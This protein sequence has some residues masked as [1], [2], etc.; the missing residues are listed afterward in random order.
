MRLAFFT[1]IVPDGL[2]SSGFEIANE[3]IVSCLRDMG[4]EVVIFGFALPRQ[5]E[6]FAD[7]VICLGRRELENAS[8]G[9]GQKLLW[10]LRA[11]RHGLPYAAAKLVDFSWGS[12]RQAIENNG[13]FDG[14]VL[15]SYQMA[16]AFPDLTQHPHIYVA[17]NVEHLSAKQNALAAT[18]GLQRFLY[19]RDA[20]ILEKL[21][22]R[23]CAAANFVWTFSDADTV[24]HKLSSDRGATLPLFVPDAATCAA[25]D[26]RESK[27]FDAG[28]I[29]TWSWQPNLVGLQWFLGEVVPLLPKS[30][31]I[32]VAGDMPHHARQ[33]LANVTFLGRVPSAAAFLQSVHVVPLISRGGTGVQLK[34]IEAFQSGL[35]CVATSSSLRGINALPE[36]CLEADDAAS[37]AAALQQLIQQARDGDLPRADGAMFRDRQHAKMQAEIHRGLAAL[38]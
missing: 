8:A 38:A 7:N 25:S 6:N 23:L 16:A 5:S 3:A 21:E 36:N 12:L 18:S 28:L 14:Y 29:G 10:L 1:S 11:V 34:T 9:G 13:S 31:R 4:H 37:F 22:T 32:A 35:A 19:R 24:G 20:G 33:E 26:H 2:P 30:M 27:Q 15:N 17:H